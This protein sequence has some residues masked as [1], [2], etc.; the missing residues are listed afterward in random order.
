MSFE[1]LYCLWH[2]KDTDQEGICAAY[3]LPIQPGRAG[4]LVGLFLIEEPYP[5]KQ[6]WLDMVEK[7]FG[8]YALLPM[9]KTGRGIACQMWIEPGSREYLRRF[10]FPNQVDAEV[11]N[12]LRPLLKVNPAVRFRVRYLPT[13]QTWTRTFGIPDRPHPPTI[14]ILTDWLE[15]GRCEATDGCVVEPDGTC[16]HGNLSWL[17]ELGLI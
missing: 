1:Q 8:S 12:S 11:I 4:W 9:G 2:K 3:G 13:L 17:L 5:V 10:D 14:D 7:E 6:Y 16:E 15:T